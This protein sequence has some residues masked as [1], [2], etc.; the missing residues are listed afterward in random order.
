M[1]TTAFGRIPLEIAKRWTPYLDLSDLRAFRLTC[2]QANNQTLQIFG[3]RYFSAITTSLM[4]DSLQRMCGIAT[5]KK[6]RQFVKTIYIKDGNSVSGLDK[7]PRTLQDGPASYLIGVRDL[8]LLLLCEQLRP[9]TIEI[10]DLLPTANGYSEPEEVLKFVSDILLDSG[11]AL[12]SCR[13]SGSWHSKT[14]TI[15]LQ[16]DS[17]YQGQCVGISKLRDAKLT[18]KNGFE[19]D[20]AKNVLY[21]CPVLEDL[22]LKFSRSSRIRLPESHGHLMPRLKRLALYGAE[23]RP[24][25]IFTILGDSRN[26]LNHLDLSQIVLEEGATWEDVLWR[27]GNEF[28]G[29]TSFKITALSQSGASGRSVVFR[30]LES[31][32]GAQYQAGLELWWKGLPE[33][34]WCSSFSYQ[35]QDCGH[36]L[37]VAAACIAFRR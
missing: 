11:L 5:H 32:V 24:Q 21:N 2:R 7:W 31:H 20:W 8:R 19:S 28:S 16:L 35:G 37:S 36:V 17:R 23:C 12:T 22:D 4:G 33:D 1:S 6:I 13:N 25:E 14:T 34:R 9:S 10:H 15:V 26:S 3:E 29:L 30:D 27:M 18:F